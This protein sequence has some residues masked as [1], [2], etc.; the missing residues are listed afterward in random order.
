MQT[1]Q[2]QPEIQTPDFRADIDLQMAI[3]AHDAISFR[4]DQRGAQMVEEYHGTLESDYAEIKK[5][6]DL[7]EQ[8][9]VF[10]TEFARYREN[11]RQ[12]F[13]SW[14]HAKSRCLSSA[15]TGPS[16]FPVRRAEK[17][18]QSEH[19][20]Y[21]EL[22]EFRQRA[23]KAIRKMLFP[24]GD[25]SVISGMDPDAVVKLREKLA[26]LKNNQ[27]VMKAANK[28]V[29]NKKLTDEQKVAQIMEQ[30]K[31]SPGDAWGLLKPDFCGRVGFADYAL[32]N[33]NANIKRVEG[34][35]A[36]LSAAAAPDAPKME[37]KTDN[38]MEI[39]EDEGRVQIRFPGKPDEKTRSLLKSN[40]FKWSPTRVTWVR[41]ATGNAR[42][43][44]EHII[45]GLQS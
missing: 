29:K 7:A 42:A 36:Q 41:Q 33:N 30:F 15:I 45:A 28:I 19:N 31:F 12:H 38:G 32:T 16:N 3:R 8:P 26:I 34:R 44:A 14:L 17:A 6:C 2:A 40:G 18:N 13:N 43:A 20:R 39:F 4:P 37:V 5:M 23:K 27:E 9:D 24:Y 10:E 25:G 21:T 11:F 22:Q 35:I 1:E